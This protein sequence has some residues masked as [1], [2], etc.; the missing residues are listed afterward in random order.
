[1]SS[2]FAMSKKTAKPPGGMSH[3]GGTHVVPV[4]SVAGSPPG[5]TTKRQHGWEILMVVINGY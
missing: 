1:M 2:H 5:M 4:S 3:S